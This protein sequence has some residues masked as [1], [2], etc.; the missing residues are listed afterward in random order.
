MPD[1]CVQP[2]YGQA[3]LHPAIFIFHALQQVW[4]IGQ[5]LAILTNSAMPQA[6]LPKL[7]APVFLI[8]SEPGA[9]RTRPPPRAIAVEDHLHRASYYYPKTLEQQSQFPKPKGKKIIPRKT[10]KR[11]YSIEEIPEQYRSKPNLTFT[12]MASNVLSTGAASNGLT[13]N[14]TIEAIKE[15]YPY[16]K[17]CQEGWQAS[18]AHCIKTPKFSN[19]LS[20]E[21]TNGFTLWTSRTRA[22]GIPLNP[23]TRNTWMS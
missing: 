14:E 9:I 15:V 19:V 22:R 4:Y 6:I 18:V 3:C 13:I 5:V 23:S 7:E 21:A 10:P 11:V 16:F 2:S 1:L 8:T 12:S 20:R 17:Y